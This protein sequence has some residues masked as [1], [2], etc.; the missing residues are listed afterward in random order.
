MV[1]TVQKQLEGL[2]QKI[3][4]KKGLKTL[5][6]VLSD[7]DWWE[8]KNKTNVL[9]I[10]THNAVKKIADETNISTDVG[11]SILTQPSVSNNYQQTWQVRITD[12]E[13]KSTTEIG[14]VSNRN[15]GHRG[16][17]NPAN[18]A[19]KR[20]YDRAVLR[21]L[22]IVG[23]LGEDEL[24]DKEDEKMENVSPDEAKEIVELLNEIFSAKNKKDLDVFS[25]KMIELKDKFNDKQ[26]QVL[27][28]AWNNQMV[29]FIKKF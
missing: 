12:S 14:E 3:K 26:L 23:F 16:R 18:M 2:D 27:R 28:N 22:G 20:A 29:K 1:K 9:Y 8:L 7:G 10:L 21:H 13:G 25:K 6:S 24:P 17:N 11:Y 19:Q 4:T 15:L 5:R